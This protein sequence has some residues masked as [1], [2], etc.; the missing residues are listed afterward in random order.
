M[1]GEAAA[2]CCGSASIDKLALIRD[3]SNVPTGVTNEGR[4]S[5]S[6][7][8]VAKACGGGFQGGRLLKAEHVAFCNVRQ[9]ACEFAK[10]C[11][12]RAS[13]NPDGELRAAILIR[14]DVD[15]VSV[16]RSKYHPVFAHP[17]GLPKA[18]LKP[19]GDFCHNI[20]WHGL[21]KPSIV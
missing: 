14:Q 1:S 21:D 7:Q 13:V 9:V 16:L 17:P 20:R 12:V 8:L 15:T 10:V 2:C 6:S 3:S 18:L 19:T 5:G 11:R 4:G